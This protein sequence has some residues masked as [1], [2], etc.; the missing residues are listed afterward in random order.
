MEIIDKE[1]MEE[2]CSI[3][4]GR[5]NPNIEVKTFHNLTTRKI[6]NWERFNQEAINEQYISYNSELM[7]GIGTVHYVRGQNRLVIIERPYLYPSKRV[8]E[9]MPKMTGAMT[10]TLQNVIDPKNQLFLYHMRGS[11]ISAPFKYQ[12]ASAGM[13]RFGETLYAGS[14]RELSEEAGIKYPI[15]S[16]NGDPILVIPFMKGGEKGVPQPLFTFVFENDLSIFDLKTSLDEISNFEKT[17][18][19]QIKDG[20]LELKEAYHFAVPLAFAETFAE[21]IRDTNTQYGPIHTSV[22]HTL[23]LI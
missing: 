10:G 3:V 4:N 8:L 12:A 7:Q 2:F 21:H 16:F 14:R 19:K 20:T 9:T 1:S 5:K 13:Q 23:D 17:I 15:S 18:K 6:Y 22:K 11:D